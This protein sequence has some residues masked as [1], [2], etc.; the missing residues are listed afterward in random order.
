MFVHRN[1]G[2]L[3]LQGGTKIGQRRV[4]VAKYNSGGGRGLKE[5]VAVF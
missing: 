1:H 3:Y 2:E 5:V 4:C